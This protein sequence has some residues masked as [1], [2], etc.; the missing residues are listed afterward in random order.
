METVERLCDRVALIDKGRKVLD[1][2]VA[3]VKR[4]HGTSTLA[5]AYE[6]D[7]AFLHALRGVTILSDSGRF[8][9][10][11]LRDGGDPQDVLREAAARVRVS[12]FEIVEPSL[13]DIFVAKV[14]SA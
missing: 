6:G 12:R 9:E 1:G 10:L 2:S 13:H 5:L 7:G 11:R 8:A 3:E 14:A 4:Q